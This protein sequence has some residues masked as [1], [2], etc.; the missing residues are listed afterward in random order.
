MFP[1]LLAGAFVVAMLL[2]RARRG[3]LEIAA[4]VYAAVAVSLNYSHIWSHLPSGER[5]TF[6]LFVCLLLLSLDSRGRP[7][8]IRRALT[9]FFVALLA[10]TFLVAPDAAASRAALLLIR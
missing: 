6:E 2:L 7:A 8:W 1:I 9:G 10:Y 5:G 3:P 4:A